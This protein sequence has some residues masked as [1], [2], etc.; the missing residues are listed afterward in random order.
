M[1]AGEG[2][3]EAGHVD[4]DGLVLVGGDLVGFVPDA[5]GAVVADALVEG[6]PCGEVRGVALLGISNEVVEASPVLSHGDAAPVDGRVA[7]E[8]AQLRVGVKFAE[9]GWHG[10]G[11]EGPLV[12]GEETVD[13]KAYEEDDEGPF[14]ARGKTAWMDD[15]HMRRLYRRSRLLRQAEACMLRGAWR[16]DFSGAFADEGF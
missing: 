10:F 7:C 13:A 14:D 4:V 3:A 5:D 6:F 1:C 15:G 9:H 8:E 16:S 11:Y 12:E 2:E